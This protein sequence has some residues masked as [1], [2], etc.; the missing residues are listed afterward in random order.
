MKIVSNREEKGKE[1]RQVIA[2][3][4]LDL[5]EKDQRIVALEA[6]LGGAS[7]FNKIEKENPEQFVQCGISE[8]NMIGVAAG[9]SL[10]GFIPFVHTFAPFATRR[11]FDQLYLSGAYSKNTINIYG[12]DPGFLAGPNGGTHTSYED[13]ALMISIPHTVVCDGS[14]EVI[15]KWIVEEFARRPGINYLRASRKKTR[16]IY[17]QGST[18]E[19]G[20]G[21]ILKTGN[22]FLILACG[23]ILSEVLDVAEELELKG[24]SIEVV[25]MFTIKPLDQTL[26][27]QESKN[28]KAIITIE[29]HNSINGLGSQV[30]CV[31]TEQGVSIPMKKIGVEERFGQVGSVDFLR[32]EYGFSKSKLMEKIEKWIQSFES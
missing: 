2:D 22:D 9:M 28:K 26:I 6:D 23:E 15:T 12:S 3:T 31:L 7:F 30:S 18:F 10:V 19:L 13:I 14:D 27:L 11:C 25:D 1:L 16:N 32:E 4:L 20:K 21:N 17:E 24:Y 5:M 8:A 29:N